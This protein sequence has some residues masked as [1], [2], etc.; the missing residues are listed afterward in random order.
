MIIDLNTEK[1]NFYPS[2]EIR[3]WREILQPLREEWKEDQ[4]DSQTPSNLDSFYGWL[5]SEWNIK[6]RT[7]APGHGPISS[8]DVDDATY[9]MIMI[10]FPKK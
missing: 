1:I 6:V 7:D 8:L 2:N 4:A 3:N 10:T 5:D 9:T